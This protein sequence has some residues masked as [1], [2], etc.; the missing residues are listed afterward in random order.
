M[1][2]SGEGLEATPGPVQTTAQKNPRYAGLL[3]VKQSLTTPLAIGTV[4]GVGALPVMVPFLVEFV[5]SPDRSF[6]E[7]TFSEHSWN[8][9]SWSI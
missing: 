9:L 2:I 4:G 6:W 1:G 5:H 3:A 8:G 7:Y